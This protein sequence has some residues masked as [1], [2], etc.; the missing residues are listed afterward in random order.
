MEAQQQIRLA[1]LLALCIAGSAH[2]QEIQNQGKKGETAA[3]KAVNISQSQLNNAGK[4]TS[5]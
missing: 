4:Q 2:S 1:A 5:D 3:I